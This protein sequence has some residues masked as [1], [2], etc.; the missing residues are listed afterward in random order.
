[1]ATTYEKIQSTTLGSAAATITFSSIPA[2]YTD[3]R[4]VA[5]LTGTGTGY[6]N[7]PSR[8]RFNSDTGSNYS[9]TYIRGDGSVASSSR[10]TNASYGFGF[11]SGS[12]SGSQP[13]FYS[14][15]IFSYAGSTNKTF[16]VETG[17]E[18]NGIYDWYVYRLVNLW[19]NTSAITS[20][21]L[22]SPNGDNLAVGSNATLYGIL[23]A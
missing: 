7:S 21:E 4:I 8:I 14:C 17:A 13:I 3:L 9:Y 1:M 18:M 20:I 16:L 23:K 12:I 5:S 22:S 15:D 6:A 2:T 19:R 10:T 11:Q